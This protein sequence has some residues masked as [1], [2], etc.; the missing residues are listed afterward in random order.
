[1]AHN[2]FL[3]DGVLLL[4]GEIWLALAEGL[5]VVRAC[6]KAGVSNAI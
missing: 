3:D 1:M 4:L 5:D 6:H 2:R